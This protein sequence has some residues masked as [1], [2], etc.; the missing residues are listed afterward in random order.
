MGNFRERKR[1]LLIVLS[2]EQHKFVL[3]ETCLPEAQPNVRNCWRNSNSIARC[4]ML[5]NMSSV[6]QKQYENFC[7]TK[8]I[9][10]NFEDL[11]GGQVALA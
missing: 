10:K 5:A 7:T 8:E 1:N 6:L 2:C 3:D 4:Y 9:M 11:L